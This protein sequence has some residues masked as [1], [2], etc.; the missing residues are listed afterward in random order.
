MAINSYSS[1]VTFLYPL[2]TS[3]NPR[4]SEVFRGYK[5]VTLAEYGLIRVRLDETQEV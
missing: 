2:K 4:F 3:E 1:N 5:N